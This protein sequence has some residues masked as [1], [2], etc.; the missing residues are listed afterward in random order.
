M[1]D[2]ILAARGRFPRRRGLETL[3]LFL[4]RIS[5]VRRVVAADE[6]DD[7]LKRDIGAA[8]APP[9]D[10]LAAHY[11]KMMEHGQLLL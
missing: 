10:R 7:W 1:S 2:G 6:L 5:S 4:L 9:Q 3:C 11:R 8:G